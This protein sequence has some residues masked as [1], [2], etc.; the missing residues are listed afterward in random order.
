MGKKR[1]A[2]MAVALVLVLAIGFAGGYFVGKGSLAGVSD[3]KASGEEGE[4]AS[5]NRTASS[6]TSNGEGADIR[7]SKDKMPYNPQM[8]F[9]DR[10]IQEMYEAV[11]AILS[12][13]PAQ[14]DTVESFG[15]TLPYAPVKIERNYCVFRDFTVNQSEGYGIGAHGSMYPRDWEYQDWIESVHYDPVKHEM[16]DSYVIQ[17]EVFSFTSVE[18]YVGDYDRAEKLYDLLSQ[19]FGEQY[20]YHF[21]KKE[22]RSWYA[23][24]IVWVTDPRQP[25]NKT[26]HT[27]NYVS[28]YPRKNGSGYSITATKYSLGENAT[29]DEHPEE[30]IIN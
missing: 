23:G 5:T 17:K 18:C 8:V 22:G 14:G 2:V 19:Y 10:D 12:H 21:E 26:R 7:K 1:T 9:D 4:R 11:I 24:I 6:T 25:K 28:M 27:Y 3:R 30:W 15:A 16:D 29:I 13:E 20:E